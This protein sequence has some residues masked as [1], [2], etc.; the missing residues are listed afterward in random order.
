MVIKIFH[1]NSLLAFKSIKLNSNYEVSFLVV[2]PIFQVLDMQLFKEIGL[3][4]NLMALGH[5]P[6]A[7]G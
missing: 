4:A 7:P 2:P 3:H 5:I 1:F 6:Q